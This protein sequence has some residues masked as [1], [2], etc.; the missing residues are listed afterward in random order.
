MPGEIE[1]I[2]RVKAE[3]EAHWMKQD[4]IL[5][6]GIGSTSSGRTGII[7]TTLKIDQQVLREVPEMVEGIPI[8]LRTSESFSIQKD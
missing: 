6:V 2:R 4:A 5:A 7:V 3:M 8:E 1:H